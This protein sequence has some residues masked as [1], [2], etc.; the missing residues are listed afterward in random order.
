[1][2][3]SFVL[4]AA[5]ASSTVG[6]SAAPGSSSA[7]TD[8]LR[9]AYE[10]MN[11]GRRAEAEQILGRL[12]RLSVTL[13][14]DETGVP[15]AYRMQYRAARDRAIAGWQSSVDGLTIR[16]GEGKDV[17]VRFAP[18]L[19]VSEETGLPRGGATLFGLDPADPRVEHVIAMERGEPMVP[20]GPSSIESEI[21]FAIGSFLGLAQAARPIGAM[22]RTDAPISGRIAVLPAEAATARLNI[23]AVN[24]LRAALAAGERLELPEPSLVV[25]PAR[26]SIGSVRQ[27]A[28]V[29][30]SIQV[31]NSGNAPLEMRVVPDCGC[32]TVRQ[33]GTIAPGVTTVI[34]GQIDTTVFPGKFDKA[35]YLYSN[36]AEIPVRRVPFEGMVRPA[37]RF[38]R[39]SGDRVIP[40]TAS[41]VTETIYL[42]FDESNPMTVKSVT[43]NGPGVKATIAPWSGMM[44]DPQYGEAAQMRKGYAITVTVPG[45]MGQGRM[46]VGM[47][48]ETNDAL[49]SALP[50]SFEVQRG[51]I[52]NPGVVFFG[53]MPQG[54]AEAWVLVSGP[55]R[56]VRVLSATVDSDFYTVRT[57]P[58]GNRGEVRVVV[59]YNG[60]APIGAMTGTVRL[61][62]DDPDQSELLIPIRGTIEPGSG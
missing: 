61:M 32:F 16:T 33:P 11:G 13:T 1:M 50:F 55:G 23:A 58:F 17:V 34:T 44:A 59:T 15:E 19:S 10:A 28:V 9:S 3:L 4:L 6:P 57:V 14:W 20:S 36:D 37:W 48:L 49:F 42:W 41:G 60:R 46:P 7:M 24:R 27:G 45:G 26:E 18:R 38:V 40:M 47:L 5:V 54:A 21:S 8:G 53:T 51:L 30:F 35:I 2:S 62:L 56:P 39:A 25:T 29:P 52:A 31:T 12:P 22:G 43:P